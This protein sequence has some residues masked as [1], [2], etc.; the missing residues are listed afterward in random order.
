MR[1]VIGERL[2]IGQAAAREGQAGLRFEEGDFLDRPDMLVMALAAQD[3][4]ENSVDV[5]GLNP[6]EAGAP[7]AAVDFE[8]RLQVEHPARAVAD[9]R[10]GDCLVA[11]RSGERGRDLVGADR[12]RGGIARDE[13]FHRH[14]S[15][16]RRS[17]PARSSRA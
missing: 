8:Q 3:R 6:G 17:A 12:D 7:R 9:D 13:E 4:I 5:V 11:E 15:S 14:A 10:G 1:A 2:R 16:S